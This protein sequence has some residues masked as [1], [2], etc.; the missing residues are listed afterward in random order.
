MKY[1]EVKEVLKSIINDE[2]NNWNSKER[3]KITFDRLIGLG[4]LHDGNFLTENKKFKDSL[5]KYYFSYD[6]KRVNTYGME[7]D[8]YVIH[9][10]FG[11]SSP[12]FLFLTPCGFFGIEDK[13]GEKNIIEW[14]TGTPGENKIITFFDRVGKNVYLLHSDDYG[15]SKEISIKYS[16]FT[17]SVISFARDE[18]NRLFG[19]AS[20]I[21]SKMT[22]YARPMLLDRNKISEIYNPSESNVDKLLM[23]YLDG[24][25]EYINQDQYELPFWDV[26]EID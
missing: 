20:D 19:D 21:I 12:D 6:Q 24:P 3:E 1:K 26:N 11:N 16:E 10:P 5:K 23:E 15:W 17:Q 4:W 7:F 13:S 8:Y 25:R 18:F 9:E 22:Y 2:S 14:N